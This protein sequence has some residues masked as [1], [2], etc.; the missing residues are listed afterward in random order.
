MTSWTELLVAVAAV[1]ALLLSL[2]S[3]LGQKGF[4]TSESFERVVKE[5]GA[6]ME[7]TIETDGP[8][9]REK[10][11][12]QLQLTTIMT[13]QTSLQNSLTVVHQELSEV[14]GKVDAMTQLFTREVQHF[15]KENMRTERR[16]EKLEKN[17]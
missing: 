7:K 1:L 4:V 9:I 11:A 5:L 17:E 13:A 16:I 6:E 15:E 3:F 14:K 2:K 10:G 12:I 8:F